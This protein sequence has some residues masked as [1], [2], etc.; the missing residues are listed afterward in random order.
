MMAWLLHILFNFW[1]NCFLISWNSPVFTKC[2][3]VD[4]MY[5]YDRQLTDKLDV[6]SFGVVL[7]ELITG[8]KPI[9][10][11]PP[12]DMVN[13]VCILWSLVLNCSLYFVNVIRSSWDIT[14]FF[15]CWNIKK[16]NHFVWNK[17]I[18][19]IMCSFA[20]GVGVLDKVYWQNWLYLKLLHILKI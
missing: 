6:Y 3:Y 16:N 19:A 15:F 11:N 10:Q 4:P 2:S 8:Q 9:S 12:G 17:K 13:L 7:F 20:W 14:F 5:S 1:I 18:F